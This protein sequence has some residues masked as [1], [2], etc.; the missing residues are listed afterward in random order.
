MMGPN[1]RRQSDDWTS[2][3]GTFSALV[4]RALPR[5][6]SAANRQIGDR[7][8]PWVSGGRR[9][10]GLLA[11]WTR[12]HPC[13]RCR[14]PH[15]QC[16]AR[17]WGICPSQPHRYRQVQ[18]LDQSRRRSSSTHQLQ[19]VVDRHP[20]E[21][22]CGL[23]QRPFKSERQLEKQQS[24]QAQRERSHRLKSEEQPSLDERIVSAEVTTWNPMELPRYTLKD[25][26]KQKNRTVS[27]L[28]QLR[29]HI[30]SKTDSRPIRREGHSAVPEEGGK[31]NQIAVG[32]QP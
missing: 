14:A 13:P 5:R 8:M 10:M 12:W 16:L 23:R 4:L 28:C 3:T 1:G 31:E 15:Q 2:R 19:S 20:L 27:G 17:P 25:S 6:F 9:A 18:R 11:G 24:N 26:W 21:T 30:K 22:G 7:E 32:R 29:E